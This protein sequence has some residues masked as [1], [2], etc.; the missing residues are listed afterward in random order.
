MRN[1]KVRTEPWRGTPRRERREK[2][3]GIVKKLI[4]DIDGAV[5]RLD[6][7][8]TDATRTGGDLRAHCATHEPVA[9]GNAWASRRTGG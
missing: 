4:G 3:N 7:D 2:M 5:A 9:A 6:Y 8:A 1:D